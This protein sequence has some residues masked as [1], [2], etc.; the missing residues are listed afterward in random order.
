MGS[1]TSSL[2]TNSLSSPFYTLFPGVEGQGIF[3][4][5]HLLKHVAELDAVSS[6]PEI[7]DT[8]LTRW[9]ADSP[10][11][12]AWRQRASQAMR[13]DTFTY[14]RNTSTVT[15]FLWAIVMTI[16]LILPPIIPQ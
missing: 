13:A 12:I 15:L 16:S 1:E 6:T 8:V 7:L 10:V 5:S 3:F 4:R 9:T 2:W 14:W 11:Q